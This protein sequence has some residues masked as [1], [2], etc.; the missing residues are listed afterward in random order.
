MRALGSYAKEDLVHLRERFAEDEKDHVW[1]GALAAEREWVIVSGDVRIMSSPTER[2]A[3]MES[4]LTAFFFCDPWMR[5]GL[6]KR[7]Y[8]LVRW[9]PEI[10]LQAKKTARGHGFKMPKRGSEL[11]QVY[12]AIK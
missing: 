9:W 5:D 6:W 4:G 8:E 2:A 3:W 1:I 12:P 11:Q 10:T 7:A